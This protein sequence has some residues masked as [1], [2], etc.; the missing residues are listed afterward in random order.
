MKVKVLIESTAS[1]LERK[2][3]E[4]FNNDNVMYRDCKVTKDQHRV[5]CVIFYNE[6]T[7]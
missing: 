6:I 5:I 7:K 4:F 3:N 2:I 1:S